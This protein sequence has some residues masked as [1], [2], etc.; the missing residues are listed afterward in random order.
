MAV[1]FNTTVAALEDELTQLILEG[2]IRVDSH[3]KILY[4]R[5][6]DQCSTTFEKSL[7][8]GKEFQRRAKAMMLRAA[9]LRNQIHVKSPP[10][11]G[12]HGELTPANSQSRMSTNMRGVA[13]GLQDICTL[14]PPYGPV[15][16]QAAQY[17]LRPSWGPGHWVLPSLHALAG[18]GEAGGC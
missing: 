16:F 17:C 2:L 1:A 10:R 6:M 4:A 12:S 5:D 9:V 11:E 15:H 8:M 7:L 18:A 13:L 3:S 14:P